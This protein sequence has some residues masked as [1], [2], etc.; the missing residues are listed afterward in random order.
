MIR[1]VIFDLDGTLVDSNELHVEA[2][3]RAFRHFG[4]VFSREALRQQVGKGADQYMPAFLTP[5]E[6]KSFGKKLDEYRSELF[7]EEYLPRVRAF[8]KVRELFVRVK[9]DGRKIALAT[10]G[11]EQ[12]LLVYKKIAQ[13]EDLV[14]CEMTADDADHSK[15]APDLFASS[16][17]KLGDV[18]AKDVIAV[19]DTPYDPQAAG[20]IGIR[21]IGL[22]C[23]GFK[24]ADLRAG[25][26]EEIYRDP[27]DLLNHYPMSALHSESAAAV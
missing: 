19:G 7:K 2:W 5:E 9:D 16:L 3:D 13:I 25:G 15:P 8:P 22:L 14:D 10:S 18:E 17:R 23:G 27:E 6:I 24:E 1:A 26:A 11:K 20:K 4:R 21:T 12:E